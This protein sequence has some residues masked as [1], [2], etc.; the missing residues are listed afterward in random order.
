V[1]DVTAS[2]S[3]NSDHLGDAGWYGGS[4]ESVL[5]DCYSST[6]RIGTY[7]TECT[8]SCPETIGVCHAS[9]VGCLLAK[10]LTTLVDSQ[11]N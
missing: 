5:G 10:S 3:Y 11:N 9:Y 1:C 6:G 4:L 7:R 2:P 8:A